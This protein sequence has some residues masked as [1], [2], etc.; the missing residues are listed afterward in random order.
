MQVQTCNSVVHVSGS[1]TCWQLPYMEEKLDKI[2]KYAWKLE[3]YGYIGFN[4]HYSLWSC[5]IIYS[6]WGCH[7][8]LSNCKWLVIFHQA[9]NQNNDHDETKMFLTTCWRHEKVVLRTFYLHLLD[10][11][12]F[13][14]GKTSKCI[15]NGH[16]FANTCYVTGGEDGVWLRRQPLQCLSEY[17]VL[18]AVKHHSTMSRRLTL[19]D[20]GWEDFYPPRVRG[21]RYE[22]CGTLTAGGWH[23]LYAA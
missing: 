2:A 6:L 7:I 11:S 18:H 8:I 14:R 15:R 12:K 19:Y 16:V 10:T 5:H 1:F 17:C 21:G 9:S 4:T 23:Q 22:T 13:K 3:R 20:K